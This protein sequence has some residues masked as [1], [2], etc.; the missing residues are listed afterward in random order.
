MNKHESRDAAGG[1]S[2]RRR[3]PAIVLIVGVV[4]FL[5][6]FAVVGAGWIAELRPP[7]PQIVLFGITAGLA[8]AYW[9]IPPFRAFAT[10]V[11]L[12]WVIGFHAVRL[13]GIVF[14]VLGGRGLLP[15][16]FATP[17]GI[18]DIAVAVGAIAIVLLWRWGTTAAARGWWAVVLR[19]WNVFGCADIFMVVFSAARHGLRDP[20][21]MHALL[22]FPLGLLL[23]FFVP[24]IIA[25][26]LLLFWRL[27]NRSGQSRSAA[28]RLM[29]E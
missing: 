23:T 22:A 27:A 21:S 29:R 24:L 20:A 2:V 5:V 26:H 7:W 28:T 6:A 3:V 8:T 15:A 14:L 11:D 16:T 10:A 13:V 1:E 17:A 12:R 25:T 9:Q 4:W 19:L 18:G